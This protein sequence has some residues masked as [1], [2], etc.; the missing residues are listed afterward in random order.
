MSLRKKLAAKYDPSVMGAI[1]LVLPFLVL[2]TVV[3]AA[4]A[5]VVGAGIAAVAGGAAATGALWG[6]GIA[7]GLGATWA[8][9]NI[10]PFI[11]YQWAYKQE[12]KE[13][14][15]AGG[16]TD[17]MWVFPGIEDLRPAKPQPGNIAQTFN[18][19]K[20]KTPPPAP[21][22]PSAPPTP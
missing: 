12:A 13:H 11:A 14:V 17:G 9:A 4:A 7:C 20:S 15:R 3:A 5:A 8:G 18:T 10:V 21:G 16:T 19:P 2:G 22:Q 6:A 1:G